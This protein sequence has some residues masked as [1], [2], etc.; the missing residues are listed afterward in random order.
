[1]KSLYLITLT[2]VWLILPPS[3]LAIPEHPRLLV[4][5]DDWK[6]L[7]SRM[8]GDPRVKKIISATIARADVTFEKPLLQYKREGRRILSVSRDAI[9]RVLDLSTAWKVTGEKKYLVRCRDE[10][11]AI[12]NFKDWNPDHHLD[13]AEMQ[14]AL[15]IG[16]DWLF[17]DLSKTDQKTIS[18]A[19]RDKGL[20]S[21]LANRHLAKRKNNWNQVC[22][23]GLVMSAIAIMNEEPGLSN[24][25]LELAKA[26]IPNGLRGG[27]PVNGAYAEGGGYWSYGTIYTILTIE[28]L[29]NVQMPFEAYRAHPGFLQ[30]AEFIQQ[31]Q[32]TSG[33][34]FNY[35]DNAPKNLEFSTALTWMAKQNQSQ[36]LNQFIAPT[37]DQLDASTH[38]RFLALAAFWVSHTAEAKEKTLALHFLGSGYSPI[39]IHRTGFESKDLFLGI[40]AGMANVNHGHMD[41]GSFVID[42]AGERWASD[43]GVQKYHDLE[44]V[45]IDLFKMT[46]DSGRWSVFRLNNFSHNTLTYNGKLH[47]IEGKSEIL[48]SKSTPQHETIVN[49]A[50]V[51]DLPKNA[52]AT[53]RFILDS[54]QRTMTITDSLSGLKPKDEITWNLYTPATPTPTDNGFLLSIK[55][56]KMQLDL[57][58]PQSIQRLASPADLPPN[59]H[60]VTNPGITRIHLNATADSEGK[61]QI[62]AIFKT[63]R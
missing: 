11:H 9:E 29:R 8:E 31:V 32:G 3:L 37:F 24:E 47:R 63:A 48:S 20:K 26:G 59:A 14:T 60:D 45:G 56:S 34:L 17:H 41:A 51:L 4:T 10:M 62:S 22:M 2:I 61:I 5:A 36:S 25:A 38:E 52:T 19:L 23:G 49:L 42:W 1:M 6:N 54:D 15:A 39:A 35:G 27:Y 18:T 46:Q 12:S 13:T 50:A 33:L 21:T 16:Y 53:R 28:A 55:K 40:K 30:S 7:P 44:S 43:L 58:S 57:T